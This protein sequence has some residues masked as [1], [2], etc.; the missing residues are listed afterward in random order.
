MFKKQ[1][2]ISIILLVI[3]SIFIINC[4]GG[5]TTTTTEQTE[6]GLE[7]DWWYAVDVD[8]VLT[9]DGEKLAMF[10]Y[11]TAKNGEAS[12]MAM[13]NAKLDMES[14]VAAQIMTRFAEKAEDG[15]RSLG[16]GDEEIVRFSQYLRKHETKVKMPGPRIDKEYTAKDDEWYYAWV[17]GY[18]TGET[19]NKLGDEIEKEVAERAM[20]EGE[21]DIKNMLEE[22][23]LGLE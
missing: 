12:E 23:D 13:S 3:M 15:M 14:K 21:E 4:S 20:T 7:P 22:V 10:F 18:L 8:Y 5:D 6:S 16:Y 2:T 9:L 1:L 19:I 11:G 17:R